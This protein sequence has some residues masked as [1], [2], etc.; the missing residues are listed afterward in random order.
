LVWAVEAEHRKKREAGAFALRSHAPAWGRSRW[1][2]FADGAGV[3]P[4]RVGVANGNEW[5]LCA[6]SGLLVSEARSRILEM[7]SALGVV[8][9][10]L[11]ESYEVAGTTIRIGAS[12]GIAIFPAH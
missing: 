1:R 8:S 7:W 5:R 2:A 10:K 3:F 9:N 6:C 4:R 11:S 12:M